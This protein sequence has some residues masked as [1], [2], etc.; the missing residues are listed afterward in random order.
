MEDYINLAFDKLGFPHEDE[1]PD[2]LHHI[3]EYLAASD[4]T[5]AQTILTTY[6]N[7]FRD[8]V[9]LEVIKLVRTYLISPPAELTPAHH[10]HP[11]TPST[12]STTDPANPTATDPAAATTPDS[13]SSSTAFVAQ[14]PIFGTL[15][16][17]ALPA[18]PTLAAS[19][20]EKLIT[21]LSSIADGSLTQLQYDFKTHQNIVVTP[22]LDQRIQAI[23]L[24]SEL[25]KT[26]PSTSTTAVQ[27]VNDIS[28]ST[29]PCDTP[30]EEDE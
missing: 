4:T 12:P 1:N 25:A 29:S 22:S 7:L 20:D 2:D 26:T 19:P 5:T 16:A 23:K 13:T 3:T 8:P 15:F 18:S 6:P 28:I 11:V 10:A 30:I 17:S 14:N 9:V 27:F 21:I 24:L